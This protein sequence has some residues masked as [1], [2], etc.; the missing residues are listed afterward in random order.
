MALPGMRRQPG[1]SII[2]PLE[3][4]PGPLVHTGASFGHVS[5]FAQN[6]EAD[7]F[8]TARLQTSRICRENAIVRDDCQMMSNDTSTLAIV[9]SKS[10]ETEERFPEATRLRVDNFCAWRLIAYTVIFGMGYIIG[11]LAFLLRVDTIGDETIAS[12]DSYIKISYLG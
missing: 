9:S 5:W 1:V 11:T 7:K 10:S 12:Y 8:T 6:D 2:G 4:K 3:T